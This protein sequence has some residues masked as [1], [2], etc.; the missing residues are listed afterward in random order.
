MTAIIQ[1]VLEELGLDWDTIIDL[2]VKG[3]VA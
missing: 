2:E 3:V 1:G